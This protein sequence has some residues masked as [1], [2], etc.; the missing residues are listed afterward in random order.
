M[1][2]QF[3]LKWNN[4]C[5]TLLQVF[6]NLL[7]T[8]TLVDCTIGADGQYL[9]AH[10]VVVSACSPYFQVRVFEFQSKFGTSMYQHGEMKAYSKQNGLL[11]I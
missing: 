11:V 5:N 3:R 10:K 2:Q 7:K 9:K 1:D 4:H 8:E 6:G